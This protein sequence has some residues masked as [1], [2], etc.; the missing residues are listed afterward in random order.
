MSTTVYYHH[1]EDSRLS[2]DY[3]THDFE[4]AGDRIDMNDCSAGTVL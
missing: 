3:V 1:P 4:D 2:I